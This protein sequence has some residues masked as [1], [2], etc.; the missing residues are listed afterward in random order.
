MI[1]DTI[2]GEFRGSPSYLNFIQNSCNINYLEVEMAANIRKPA[3]DLHPY[4]VKYLTDP[5]QDE[6]R[7]LAL[8]H[9]KNV[10]VSKYGN[11]N[12]ITRNKARMANRTYIIEDPKNSADFSSNIIAGENAA[13][14]L[15]LQRDYIEKC[16]TL[17]EI[18]GYIGLGEQAV[19][20]QF[21]Y[22]P[23]GA[24]IAGMQK[25][26]LFPRSDVESPERLKEPFKPE[27][28]LVY[29]AECPAKGLPGDQGIIVDIYNFTTYVIGPD[30]FGE[31]KKG[32]LRMFC[33]YMY[34]R[35]GLVLHAGAKLVKVKGN[36]F[37]MT[38]KGLSGTGKTTTTFSKQGELTQPI[39]DDM[40]TLWAGGKI[41]ITENGCF[42]KTFGLT[43]ESEPI[44]YDGTVNKDAWV[45]NV[46]QDPS[47]G[48]DFSK[49][50]L[51]ID[52]VKKYKDVLIFTGADEK[53][54]DAFINRE[55]SIKEVLDGNGVPKDGWD[56]VVWT[57]NGR[58]IIPMHAIKD[59]ADLHKIPDVR[60]MGILNRDEGADAATPGIIKFVSPE[61]AAGYFMLGETSKTSAAGKE[62]GKT[63]SP[64]TQPFFPRRME[65]Q[66]IRFKELVATM[67][68]VITW[69]MNT[70]FI[71]GDSRD[72]EAG[73]ALKV[74]IRHSSA[75]LEA[76]VEDKIKWTSDPDFGYLIP[77]IAAP[78][79]S[80]LMK[81]VPA[82]ILYPKVFYEKNGRMEEYSKWVNS[83]NT[84]R[85]AFL[86]KNNV[87]AEIINSV[88]GK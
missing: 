81:A 32:G 57:Q 19:P 65:L 16:G 43:P 50:L 1:S 30:Y 7:E 61:Q 18:Q 23:D 72:V 51:T 83:I 25:V 84:A 47:G 87:A 52:E 21:L 12:K 24:N 63:R 77:D 2:G 17:I 68:D 9:S 71:G 55:V 75:M 20:I 70:G 22:T 36:T 53:N 38:I 3:D 40:V 69:M 31:S 66:A 5:S 6:L 59:A 33:E 88:C 64:F 34:Q 78:E 14:Y 8:K 62:R 60:F 15:D 28:R 79:N 54:I 26:L 44:I 48:Y 37:S 76:L 4:R 49:E 56:F 46:Y 86:E 42:A 39:Q 80:E 13:K 73:K 45:E 27:M 29:T 74:K 10:L 11:L 85:K 41:S 82:E 67:P 35:G 58:S